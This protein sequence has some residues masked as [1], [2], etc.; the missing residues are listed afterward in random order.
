MYWVNLN[1][2]CRIKCRSGGCVLSEEVA[3]YL[4][5]ISYNQDNQVKSL[6][7]NDVENE[8]YG[9]KLAEL[10]PNVFS[11]KLGNKSGIPLQDKYRHLPFHL[12]V[13]K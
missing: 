7:K 4:K 10:Y 3:F 12:R 9:N 6:K 5:L 11:G 2:K 8:V 1:I 13:E